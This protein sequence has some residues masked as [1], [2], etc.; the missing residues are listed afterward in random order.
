VTI[1]ADRSLFAAVLVAALG[2]PVAALAAPVE[3]T[4]EAAP[5]LSAVQSGTPVLWQAEST[6]CAANDGGAPSQFLLDPGCAVRSNDAGA[7][8]FSDTDLN[9]L[10]GLPPGTDLSNGLPGT[11]D[12]DGTTATLT[13]AGEIWGPVVKNNADSPG[14]VTVDAE[15]VTD[16][17]VTIDV[18]TGDVASYAWMASI[19]TPLGAGTLS[20]ALAG[21]DERFYSAEVIPGTAADSAVVWLCGSGGIAGQPNDTPAADPGS[22]GTCPPDDTNPSPTVSNA[23][24]DPVN[25]TLYANASSATLAFTPRAWAPVDG[26]ITVPEPG[27]PAAGAAGL[28]A[29][30]GL[31]RR[32]RAHRG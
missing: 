22:L 24:W 29:L 31:A 25:G 18:A 11:L 20:V 7:L 28:L 17:V 4:F 9:A 32:V 15:S 19:T 8:F 16:F 26:R 14:L 23:A 1:R 2:A 13:V 5:D 21:A 3:T 30:L 6:P 10:P 27:A 12:S